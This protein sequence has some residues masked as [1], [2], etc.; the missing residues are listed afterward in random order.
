[1]FNTWDL[2][3]F[4]DDSAAN[5]TSTGDSAA[6]DPIDGGKGTPK[7]DPPADDKSTPKPKDKDKE[8]GKGDDS[9]G[10]GSNKDFTQDDVNNIVAKETKKATE[11]MLRQLGLKDFNSAKDGLKKFKEWQD[12]QKTEAEK[13]KEEL[14]A[15]QRDKSNLSSENSSL[16]AQ[17]VAMK[18]G[19]LP[20]SVEDVVVL[21]ERLVDDDTDMEEAIEKVV[22]KYPQ[23]MKAEPEEETEEKPP[24]FSKGNHQK[25][26]KTDADVWL[27]AFRPT[28]VSKDT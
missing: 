16:K 15:L 22:E 8:S 2:Q 6:D 4:A 24:T 27:E 25:K 11:K 3:F 12:S 5:D 20:D 18:Q 14:E 21:A 17:V 13:Q 26:P 19:V 1:M 23:F 9:K 28:G 10:G 7:N